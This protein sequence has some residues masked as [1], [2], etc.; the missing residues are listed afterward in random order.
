[1]KILELE[2]SNVRGVKQITIPANGGNVVVYGPNGTGKSAIVDSI[3][4][5][6]TGKISR[7]SGEGSKGLSVKEHGPHVDYRDKLKEVVVKAPGVPDTIFESKRLSVADFEIQQDGK[8]VLLTY[9]KQLRK[10]SELLLF[11]GVDILNNFSVPGIA[12][13]LVRDY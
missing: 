6:L 5:L 13:E 12:E 7:L 9:P 3:D 8:L 11:D 1:M 10:G 2:I 4:F